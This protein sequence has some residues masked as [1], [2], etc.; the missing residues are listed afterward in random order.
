MTEL[1]FICTK[2]KREFDCDVGKISF[3][4]EENQPRFENDIVCP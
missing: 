4:I 3:P 1:N 2:C